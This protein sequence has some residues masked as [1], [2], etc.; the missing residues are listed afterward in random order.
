MLV[1]AERTVLLADSSK[2]GQI[3]PY[4][5]APLTGLYAV[6]TDDAAL[7]DTLTETG[8]RV[9]VPDLVPEPKSEL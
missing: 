9:L 1:G 5:V 4:L 8:V 3:A 6:V 7:A 2:A